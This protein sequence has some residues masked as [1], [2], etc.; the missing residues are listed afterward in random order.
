M[1]FDPH[2]KV[3]ELVHA[4]VPTD[5]RERNDNNQDDEYHHHN[6]NLILLLHQERRQRYPHIEGS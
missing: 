5:Q 3:I 4:T 6:L 1:I 2:A